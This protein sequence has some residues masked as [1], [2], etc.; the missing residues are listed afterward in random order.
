MPAS[1]GCGPR[2]H[3]PRRV[4][5]LINMIEM[6]AREKV[7]FE[8]TLYGVSVVLREPYCRRREASCSPQFLENAR[9]RQEHREC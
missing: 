1:M 4:E 6:E 3:S 9:G 8:C 5:N 7:K 2:A